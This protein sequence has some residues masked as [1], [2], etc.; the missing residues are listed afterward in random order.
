[1]QPFCLLYAQRWIGVPR[2]RR[3]AK[4]HEDCDNESPTEQ[5]GPHEGEALAAD[6]HLPSGEA[7]APAH[8][9]LHG[10]LSHVLPTDPQPVQDQQHPPRVATQPVA[11]DGVLAKPFA[12]GDG[13]VIVS[14]IESTLISIVQSHDAN[15]A[16]L[17]T[18]ALGKVCTHVGCTTCVCLAM[19]SLTCFFITICG[20]S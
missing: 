13:D 19:L 4:K 14:T 10:D 15:G 18:K 16:Q 1:M 20:S 12:V 3:L 5:A 7:Q 8:S 2:K 6:I 9:K 17:P 11:R